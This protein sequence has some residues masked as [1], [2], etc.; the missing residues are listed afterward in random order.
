[1]PPS[2]PEAK[3]IDP[4]LLLRTEKL[5][6]GDPGHEQTR[7]R[8]KSDAASGL[9]SSRKL[10]RNNKCWNGG[11]RWR[12]NERDGDRSPVLGRGGRLLL[13]AVQQL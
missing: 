12:G 11:E 2:K 9:D 1:M 3:F 10:L 5:P 6:E 8:P 13:R 7:N 4:M